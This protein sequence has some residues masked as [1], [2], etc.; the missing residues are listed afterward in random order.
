MAN[1][2][3]R[4]VLAGLAASL[5]PRATAAQPSSLGAIA[6][7]RGVWFGSAIG[8]EIFADPAYAAAI[9]R[10][11]RMVTIENAVKLGFIRPEPD[12]FTPEMADR[13]VLWAGEKHLA[14]R[15]HTLVWN[16]N[17]PDWL[18]RMSGREVAR[19]M[20]AH[21]AE[22]AGRYAGLI[23][24]WDVVNEPF[25]PGFGLPGG[26]RD[27]PFFAAMGKDY[28]ARAF[29]AA[30]AADPIAKLTL[31]EA[32]TEEDTDL[33]RRVRAGLL[34][35]VD[36]LLDAGVPLQGIGLQGHLKPHLPYDDQAFGKFLAALAER[37]LPIL[38]TE[39]DV[40]DEG[41]SGDQAAVDRAVAARYR[42]FLTT[43]MAEPAV[44]GVITWQL[45]DR[46]SWYRGD[47]YKNAQR[48]DHIHRLRPARPLPLDDRL[49]PKAAWAA[50][51]A[52]FEGRGL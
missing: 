23:Q 28:I 36:D 2:S 11:C 31:N 45:S 44:K 51:A 15:G 42:Q 39:L 35:L 46:Y 48:R 7:A 41:F 10:E 4:A 49:R 12:R 14:I 33:G 21:I 43:C 26:Y 8:E 19:L 24:S 30:R 16:D 40:S 52:A 13:L 38:I 29:H 34:G 1:L 27:G 50:I 17:N 6:D 3:R 18:K 47:W 9:A 20:D 5:L 22:T 37:K 25:Y 32:F